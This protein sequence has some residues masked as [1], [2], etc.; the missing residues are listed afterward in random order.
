MS[1]T[2][3]LLR[4]LSLSDRQTSNSDE[5]DL[6][7]WGY[8]SMLPVRECYSILVVNTSGLK[9]TSV[10]FDKGIITVQRHPKVPKS[11]M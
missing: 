7:K 2:S 11:V 9:C 10:A 1:L 6:E 3:R 5:D 8:F 4:M